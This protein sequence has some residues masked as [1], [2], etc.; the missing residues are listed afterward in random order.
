MAQCLGVVP[1]DEVVIAR[2]RACQAPARGQRRRVILSINQMDEEWDS[3]EEVLGLVS[4]DTPQSTVDR[5]ELQKFLD[6]AMQKLSP[7]HRLVV[8]LYDVQ[9]VPHEQIGEI[10]SQTHHVVDRDAPRL[11]AERQAP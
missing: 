1:C 3:G 6:G 8:T 4:K 5:H 7:N 9:G 2:A 11:D 10:D